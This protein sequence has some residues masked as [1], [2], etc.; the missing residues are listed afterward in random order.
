MGESVL[1]GRGRQIIEIPREHWE[2][3]IM[4]RS[5]LVKARLGFM[6]EEHHLIRNFAVRELPRLGA[7][8]PPEFIGQELNLPVARVNSILDDL[9]KRLTFLFRNPKGAVAWAYPVTA[10]KTP[11][12]I[13]FG[14]GEQLYAA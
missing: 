11:H 13:T 12:R 5:E 10:D 3:G 14:T 2:K 1:I 6:S 4:Q 8:L 9:E 7:P